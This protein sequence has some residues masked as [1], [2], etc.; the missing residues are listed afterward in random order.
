M[1]HFISI[2]QCGFSQML[3]PSYLYPNAY[4]QP[5][6]Y[7]ILLLTL[8]L[9]NSKVHRIFINLV[10]NSKSMISKSILS[11]TPVSPLLDL[12]HYPWW[13]LGISVWV[14]APN[15]IHTQGLRQHPTVSTKNL[16]SLAPKGIHTLKLH[17]PFIWAGLVTR[18]GEIGQAV[19]FDLILLNIQSPENHNFIIPEKM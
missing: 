6:L 11:V 4:L 16:A 5:I 13:S 3:G 7:I 12:H 18:K 9:K 1:S 19:S 8:L 15:G 17:L 14:L 2:L 10:P